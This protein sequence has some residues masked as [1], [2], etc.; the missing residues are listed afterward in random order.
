MSYTLGA[1]FY[2]WERLAWNHAIWHVFVLAG[3]ILH[4]FS[5]FFYVVPGP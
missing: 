5:V 1:V 2:A 3:S 4:F